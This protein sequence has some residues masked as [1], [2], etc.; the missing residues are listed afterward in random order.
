MAHVSPIKL[1]HFINVIK[2]NGF[3]YDRTSGDHYIYKRNGKHISIPHGKEINAVLAR[4]LLKE[5]NI[6]LL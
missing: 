4:R 1:K 3:E 2:K 6:K 5:N